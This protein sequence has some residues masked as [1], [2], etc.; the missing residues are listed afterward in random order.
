MNEQT[1]QPA[2]N[3]G[4]TFLFDVPYVEGTQMQI[5]VNAIPEEVRA[6]IL[7]KGIVAYVRNSVNQANNRHKKAM[8]P[9][10]AYDKAIAADAMQTAVPQP[11]G[12][13]PADPADTLVETATAARQRLYDGEIRKTGTRKARK[14]ADPLDS[15]ITQAVVRELYDKNRE[16]DSKYKYTDATSEVAKAGGGT[17]YLEAKI[18]ERVKAGADEAELRKFMES[19]YVQPAKLILGQ[20][21]TPTTK[22]E[23]LL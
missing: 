8:E 2:E 1:T 16:A 11:Q 7:K 9:W 13:R 20:R 12:E 5:D 19:R 23:S 15:I 18:A 14:T 17:A 3:S 10:E 4:N 22:G 21:D 6:D